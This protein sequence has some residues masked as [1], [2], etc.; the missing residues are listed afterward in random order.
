[1]AATLL[2]STKWCAHLQLRSAAPTVAGKKQ[3]DRDRDREGGRERERER[4]EK[5][6]CHLADHRREGHAI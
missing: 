2:T 4:D 5:V 3:G 6:Q 1:V